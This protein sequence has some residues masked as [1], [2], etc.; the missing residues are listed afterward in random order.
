MSTWQL[1][2]HARVY[3]R[4]TESTDY[5]D[6]DDRS[7]LVCP[8]WFKLLPLRMEE[9]RNADQ[10]SGDVTHRIICRQQPV[11]L[12]SM[13]WLESRGKRYEFAGV[14]ELAGYSEYLEIMA[15]ETAVHDASTTH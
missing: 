6:F 8:M 15:V 5:G 13:D 7:Q 1:D 10:M 14:S 2:R 11:Q 4:K 3:R 12:L 9:R